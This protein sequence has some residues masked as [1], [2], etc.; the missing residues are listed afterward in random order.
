MAKNGDSIT[1]V[2]EPMEAID[3]NNR[4]ALV[5]EALRLTRGE[6]NEAEDL[7]QE[8]MLKALRYE[9]KGNEIRDRNRRW[10]VTILTNTYI[11]RYR[12]T[13][14]RPLEIP[15]EDLQE[16]V[17]DRA[18][19]EGAAVSTTG[20]GALPW[21]EQ[22]ELYRWWFSDEVLCALSQLPEGFRSAVV[23]VDIEGLSYEEA[24]H[25]LNAPLGTVMSRIHR[26]RARM[27][28]ALTSNT[29]PCLN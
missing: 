15:F 26:G 4:P 19:L 3:R 18:V 2:K 7:V 10:L 25:R 22:R 24:A 20:T 28:K 5:Q 11:D 8:T 13:A 6:L 23:L 17:G 29:S 14:V 9:R 16:L 1:T 21:D 27:R 12:R